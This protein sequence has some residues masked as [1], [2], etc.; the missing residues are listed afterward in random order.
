M[1]NFNFD[2]LPLLNPDIIQDPLKDFNFDNL[3]DI[4]VSTPS[5]PKIKK[6]NIQEHQPDRNDFDIDLELPTLDNWFQENYGR[7][8]PY[9]RGQT[10]THNSLGFDHSKSADIQV[11]PD[12]NEGQSIIKYLRDNNIPFWAANGAIKGSSTGPHIHLGFKSKRLD[13]NQDNSKQVLLDLSDFNFD[14]L[15]Q[16]API[17]DVEQTLTQGENAQDINLNEFNFEGLDNL[18][19]K[20]LGYQLPKEQIEDKTEP[21]LKLDYA[22]KKPEFSQ[23]LLENLS[24]GTLEAGLAFA[25][26]AK[27]EGATNKRNPD[28]LLKPVTVS[29]VT[30]N[31]TEPTNDDTLEAYLYQ[32]DPSGKLVSA[33]HNYRKETGKNLLFP[34]G[35]L[36]YEFYDG[37]YHTTIQLTE[38]AA[39]K[40]NA[41]S[42]GG[43][44]ELRKEQDLID[45]E[46]KEYVLEAN[47][48]KDDIVKQFSDRPYLSEFT[49]SEAALGITP[50][51]FRENISPQEAEQFR[52]GLI[53]GLA[54]TTVQLAH[55][56][57]FLGRAVKTGTEKGYHSQEYLNL[58]NEDRLRQSYLNQAANDLPNVEEV[59]NEKGEIISY[60]YK[61]KDI[62]GFDAVRL[63]TFRGVGSAAGAAP[64]MILAGRALP[65]LVYLENAHRGNREAASQAF[66]TAIMIGAGNI[67]GGLTEDAVRAANYSLKA[68]FVRQL[69]TR[70]VQGITDV[71]QDLLINS[72]EYAL[73][74]KSLADTIP[75]FASSAAFPVGKVSK[76]IRDT[77]HGYKSFDS[78]TNDNNLLAVDNNKPI[79]GLEIDPNAPSSQLRRGLLLRKGETPVT[80]IK[81]GEALS[82]KHNISRGIVDQY[83]AYDIDQLQNLKLAY[84]NR[85]KKAI[86][87]IVQPEDIQTILDVNV[88]RGITKEDIVNQNVL[89]LN[90]STNRLEINKRI[91]LINDLIQ[92]KSLSDEQGIAKIELDRLA[93]NLLDM[94]RS[95]N[96]KEYLDPSLNKGQRLAR[97]NNLKDSIILLEEAIPEEVKKYVSDNEASIRLA[98]KH[99]QNEEIKKAF[100]ESRLE[101]RSK[102][103][104]SD[105]NPE[106]QL[107]IDN[108][109]KNLTT[110]QIKEQSEN[111]PA[112][113]INFNPIEALRKGKEY[114]QET[115][116]NNKFTSQETAYKKLQDLKSIPKTNQLNDVGLT[117]QELFKK[118]SD[119]TYLAAFHIED[120]YRKGIEPTVDDLMNKLRNDLGH[121][122]DNIDKDRIIRL[123]KDS[124]EFYNSKENRAIKQIVYHGT[125]RDFEDFKPWDGPEAFANGVWF[126]PDPNYASEY[127]I[128]RKHDPQYKQPIDSG[129]NVR[130]SILEIK[131]PYHLQE[132]I[133]IIDMQKI[134]DAYKDLDLKEYTKFDWGANE[135]RKKSLPKM[136]AL[137]E[138]NENISKRDFIDLFRKDGSKVTTEILRRSGFDSLINEDEIVV[139][140]VEN[141]TPLFTERGQKRVI[142]RDIH[143]TVKVNLIESLQSLTDKKGLILNSGLNPDIFIDQIKLL[144]KGFTDL[145]AFTRSLTDVYGK[146]IEPYAS[147]LFELTKRKA[148]DFWQDETGA[149]YLPNIFTKRFDAPTSIERDKRFK[150]VSKSMIRKSINTIALVQANPELSEPYNVMRD[151]EGIG[152]AKFAEIE[153]D[154]LES[155]TLDPVFRADVGKAIFIGNKEGKKFTNA[156][157]LTG[158]PSIGLPSLNTAQIEAYNKIRQAS[159]KTLDIRLN[160]ELFYAY[161]A[162]NVYV[163]GSVDYNNQLKNITR[164][165]SHYNQLKNEGYISLKRIGDFALYAENPAY[166]IGDDRRK[167]YTHAKTRRER[168]EIEERWRAKGY[169]N[170]DA[171]EISELAKDLSS[172]HFKDLRGKLSPSQFEDLVMRAG[173]YTNHVEVQRLRE[174]VYSKYGSH[175]YRLK[176][177]FTEGFEETFD[178]ALRSIETQA[179]IYERSFV[180]NIG[181]EEA[182]KALNNTSLATSD[183]DLYNLMSSYIVDATSPYEVNKINDFFGKARKVTYFMNLAY[184]VSQFFLN[185]VAQPISQN[186]SYFA[187]MPEV[188]NT[189]AETYFTRGTLLAQKVIKDKYLKSKSIIPKEFED[190][191]ERGFDEKLLTGRLTDE[192]V[193]D[194]L[195]ENDSKI[196]PKGFVKKMFSLKTS[197]LFMRAGEVGTRLQAFSEAYLIGKEKLGLIDE[198]L[199]RFMRRAVDST[200]GVGGTG[201]NPYYMRKIGEAGKLL[202][203]FQKF[204]AMWAENLALNIKADLKHHK[205]PLKSTGRHLAALAL[206]GGI[207][208]LPLAGFG[209][210]IYNIVTDDDPKEQ[211]NEFFDDESLLKDLALYGLPSIPAFLLGTN[212]SGISQKVG[213][214]VPML[215]NMANYVT[216]DEE[217]PTSAVTALPFYGTYNQH[218]SKPYKQLKRGDTYRAVEDFSPRFIRGPL[219]AYRYSD[220][221]GHQAYDKGKSKTIVTGDVDNFGQIF[222]ITPAQISD[223]YETKRY[224]DLRKSSKE[225]GAAIDN[226]VYGF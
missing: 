143:D 90:E 52:I 150:R 138:K 193:A 33:Y 112:P 71:S 176:R 190:L 105:K 144:Y 168:Q 117:T 133:S 108:N 62:T 122:I 195:Q 196:N 213:I 16:L 175:S 111:A 106:K 185:Y 4:T 118:A 148:S 21:S 182:F 209:R 116:E 159:E 79:D 203:Q 161:K 31:K 121:W 78:L 129:P 12:S 169:L 214:S 130:P 17:G 80:T 95:L 44:K 156:Q 107:E 97:E 22:D 86:P 194:T 109:K 174:E 72:R 102:E 153:R 15:P 61:G 56:L 99:G 206:T 65:L 13:S 51:A 127:S 140:D 208:S 63:K 24:K 146:E 10:K 39:R 36:G 192:L 75:V 187:R 136:D 135:N 32:Q 91:N 85:L 119:L 50:S 223:Y 34:T 167:V 45:S 221:G 8:L 73:G 183:P 83:N 124:V 132:N 38:E 76:K 18:D 113:D 6:I 64:K 210:T 170:F 205:I 157:L 11:N 89:S 166:P 27:Y 115:G 219:K 199:W 128:I 120:F 49:A 141:I 55:N 218:I 29:Y 212:A 181:R 200:Q 70:G 191:V 41:Y 162:L 103:G 47:K 59:K 211:F 165:I 2:N 3:P 19:T 197:S 26:K 104:L 35:T 215:D 164:I 131:N 126:T 101:Q 42:K 160:H 216:D 60:K 92:Q 28:R 222:N 137:I 40:L 7:R 158:D 43:L 145:T 67:T 66:T 96:N 37:M 178:N 48:I 152:N 224:K 173:A 23:N 87:D 186:Y 220:Y 179:R 100:R 147:S 58:L 30:Y 68:R 20:E 172:Q 123:F 25:T 14:N 54:M 1:N 142:T 57:E 77:F 149:L 163:P 188:T 155:T 93:L 207:S 139:F 180:T 74:K 201:E 198:D 69:K 177:D 202:Y 88:G 151:A 134:R 46:R 154:L 98:N 94:K 171:H 189:D 84:Q 114:Y 217:L 53:D 125:D 110:N 9:K 204:P 82:N 5:K 184:D 226:F 81:S 225:I